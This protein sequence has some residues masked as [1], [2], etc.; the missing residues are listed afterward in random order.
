[1]KIL[2]GDEH[3]LFRAALKCLL[4]PLE[5]GIAFVEAESFNEL[6]KRCREGG[7]YD[8]ILTDLRMPGWRG[9]E[10]LRDVRALQ[11]D[12]PLVVVS[13]SEAVGDIR[14]ALDHGANG[15]IPK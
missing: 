2:I 4:E 7:A 15:F 8:L 6:M 14:A 5:D 12:T 9:F 1:M 10:S 11:R 3:Q 13:A